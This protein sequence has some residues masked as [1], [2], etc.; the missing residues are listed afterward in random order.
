MISTTEG[1]RAYGGHVTSLTTSGD[2]SMSSALAIT[3]MPS[4]P[5][6]AYDRTI[7]LDSQTVAALKA[8]T[9]VIVVHGLDPK[10]PLAATS[11]ALC[12]ALSAAQMSAMPAGAASTGSGSIADTEDA[13]LLAAG[14]GA[15][16]LAGAAGVFAYRH[17]RTIQ[18]V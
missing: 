12:G 13:G 6:A 7:T 18:P 1:L 3:R 9:A 14:A 11:P 2:T 15:I 4:G 10:L 17:R 5:S 8:G 16:V